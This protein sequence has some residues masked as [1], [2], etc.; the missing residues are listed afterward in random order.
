MII[1]LERVIE[2]RFESAEGCRV[3][4]PVVHYIEVSSG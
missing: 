1:H 4:D 3:F 2:E